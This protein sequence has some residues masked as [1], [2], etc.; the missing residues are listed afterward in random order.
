M[1]EPRQY[2]YVAQCGEGVLKIGVSCRPAARIKQLGRIWGRRPFLFWQTAM[3]YSTAN[4][5]EA[6]TRVKMALRHRRLQNE[7]FVCTPQ[8]MMRVVEMAISDIGSGP[9][10]LPA[11]FLNI[12]NSGPTAFRYLGK[13]H[14]AQRAYDLAQ[15][16]AERNR[17]RRKTP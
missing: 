16:L 17:S 12:H 9:F 5:R 4:A 3:T 10:Y 6:E 14:I 1:A 13:R 11:V 7:W 8:K 15:A 2:L